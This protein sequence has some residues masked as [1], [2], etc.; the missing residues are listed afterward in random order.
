MQATSLGQ[1]RRLVAMS[2]L[3]PLA[4]IHMQS[5]ICSQSLLEGCASQYEPPLTTLCFSTYNQARTDVKTY[6]GKSIA[7]PHF[8]SHCRSLIT[9]TIPFQF[10]HYTYNRSNTMDAFKKFATE[11]IQEQRQSTAHS[12]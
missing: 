3:V 1:A 7:P 2:D 4:E 5:C 8:R 12:G 11:K 9:H 10:I 6:R